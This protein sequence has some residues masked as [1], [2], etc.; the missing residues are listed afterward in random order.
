M[1]FSYFQGD[2]G[3]LF[4]V[5]G[6]GFRYERKDDKYVA[7]EGPPGQKAASHET[8]AATQP[9]DRRLDV[10]GMIS[11]NGGRLVSRQDSAD[12]GKVLHGLQVLVGSHNSVQEFAVFAAGNLEQRHQFYP[13]G[14]AFRSQ[15]RDPNGDGYEIVYTAE[16]TKVI[17]EK[18]IVDGGVN[19]GPIKDQ[20]M[21]CRGTVRANHRWSGTF[22]VWEPVPNGFGERLALREYRKG[23]LVNSTPFHV[24]KLALPVDPAQEGSAAWP[25]RWS[26]DSPEW[27]HSPAWPS[28]K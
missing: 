6:P 22:L 4:E 24:E 26:W 2:D 18:V 27:R 10:T 14:R 5:T 8:S 12:G 21:V 23:A 19:I 16:L 7:V 17:A 15:M 9:P 1:K 11:E 25:W 3:Y 28:E 20:D 13:N